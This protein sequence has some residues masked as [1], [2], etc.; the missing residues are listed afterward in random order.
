MPPDPRCIRCGKMPHLGD[1]DDPILNIRS[2]ELQT[3][4]AENDRLATLA[5]QNGQQF[6]DEIDAHVKENAKLREALEQIAGLERRRTTGDVA[7]DIARAALSQS[8]GKT[9]CICW[10]DVQSKDCPVHGMGDDK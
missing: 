7:Q 8:E 10:M 4:R 2:S 5:Y 1:C 3:L 6:A 9:R